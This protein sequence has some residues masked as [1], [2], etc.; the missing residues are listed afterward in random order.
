M[1]MDRK[2]FFFGISYKENEDTVNVIASFYEEYGIFQ[3]VEFVNGSDFIPEK[4]PSRDEVNVMIEKRLEYLQKNNI[5]YEDIPQEFVDSINK[6]LTC[7]RMTLEE[8]KNATF[9][10]SIPDDLKEKIKSATNGDAIAFVENPKI[11]SSMQKQIEI[12]CNSSNPIELAG[13]DQ[14][15]EN[16]IREIFE[17]DEKVMKCVSEDLPRMKKAFIDAL[18]GVD[19]DSI[20]S[21]YSTSHPELKQ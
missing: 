17:N 12:M 11:L 18:S 13:R 16:M 10:L 15:L 8:F 2:M 19:V 3:Y 6:R 5:L 20:I 9:I 4:C 7:V 21:E 14:F 1:E